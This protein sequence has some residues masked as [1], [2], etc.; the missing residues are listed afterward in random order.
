MTR[1][2][3]GIQEFLELRTWTVFDVDDSGRVQHDD[4]G[5]ERAQLSLLSLDPLPAGPV[6]LDELTPLVHDPEHIHTLVDVGPGTVAYST[7]RLNVIQ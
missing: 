6:G 3:L 7:N 2:G 1:H 4:G 5:N